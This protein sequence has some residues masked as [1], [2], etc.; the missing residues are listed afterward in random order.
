MLR[1]NEEFRVW[2]GG[3]ETPTPQQHQHFPQSPNPAAYPTTGNNPTSCSAEG[4]RGGGGGRNGG[5]GPD[6]DYNDPAYKK[7][8]MPPPA[9][10][11]PQYND[12]RY[13]KI[14]KYFR[15][16]WA[17]DY[18]AA[19]NDG[20]QELQMLREKY[21]QAWC[22]QT[23]EEVPRHTMPWDLP[24]IPRPGRVGG[25]GGGYAGGGY[26]QPQPG[27]GGGRG[28]QAQPNY[29]GGGYQQPLQY[30]NLEDDHSRDPPTRKPT[31]PPPEGRWPET[32]GERYVNIVKLA[33]AYW[34]QESAGLADSNRLAAL[35]E[36]FQQQWCNITGEKC[37]KW[38][39]PWDLRHSVSE[40]E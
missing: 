14:M 18:A 16:I 21:E 29:G 8:N 22:N 3:D 39:Q 4:Y 28:Y 15:Q 34:A 5:E 27:Y 32:N 13:V 30:I 25:G 38:K 35:R 1:A 9:E 6:P 12:G 33:R 2:D 26:Q 37:P 19:M 11:Y 20:A 10:G 40:R 23:G 24:H 31:C 17:E 36:Q 7:S